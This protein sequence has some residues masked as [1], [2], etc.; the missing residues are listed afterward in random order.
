MRD[1]KV[2]R[3]RDHQRERHQRQSAGIT[4]LPWQWVQRRSE[5][6]ACQWRRLSNCQLFFPT[7][8]TICSFDGIGTS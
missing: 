2:H 1:I 5:F 3:I 4:Y 7:S 6:F 8:Y